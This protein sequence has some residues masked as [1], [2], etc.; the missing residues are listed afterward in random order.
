MS[1]HT[2]DPVE[3][4]LQKRKPTK[5]S[6]NKAD[7]WF[8]KNKEILA[9]HLM[10]YDNQQDLEYSLDN[11]IDLYDQNLEIKTK[12]GT[13]KRKKKT[14]RSISL[15]S[16][17]VYINLMLQNY[18]NAKYWLGEW[19][20]LEPKNKEAN[21]VYSSLNDEFTFN[22]K[23]NQVVE[24]YDDN[25]VRNN[26]VVEYY[27][28]DVS[29]HNQ[30]LPRKPRNK[31]KKKNKKNKK[32]KASK[33][34]QEIDYFYDHEIVGYNQSWNNKSWI[35]Q[36]WNNQDLEYIITHDEASAKEKVSKSSYFT[37]KNF[38]L[39]GLALLAFNHFKK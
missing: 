36:S 4:F 9:R 28:N 17:I 24:Y 16:N 34:I 33:H 39:L 8:S 32:E 26:Q 23:H 15:L 27:D 3:I 29:K 35:N 5:K 14:N 21:K 22:T 18:E 38:L 19:L 20:K 31:N 37:M 6:M 11:F 1:H 12:K 25:A 7:K 30:A 2:Q 13:K 10:T